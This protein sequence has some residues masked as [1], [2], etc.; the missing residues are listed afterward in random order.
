[1]GKK[2]K[3][4]NF[5]KCLKKA[6]TLPEIRYLNTIRY[7]PVYGPCMSIYGSNPSKY[8]KIRELM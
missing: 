3:N 6:N 5:P 1:M 7:I 4:I 2:N 8:G